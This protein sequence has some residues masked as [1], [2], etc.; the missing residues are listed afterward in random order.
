MQLQVCS[1]RDQ[2]FLS[3]MVFSMHGEGPRSAST[4]M[5]IVTPTYENL[6][7]RM[8]LVSERFS[9]LEEK[10]QNLPYFEIVERTADFML[11]QHQLRVAIA[12]SNEVGEDLEDKHDARFDPIALL[13]AYPDSLDSIVMFVEAEMK[14]SEKDLLER[15]G[16][17]LYA[18]NTL[19]FAAAL[20]LARSESISSELMEFLVNHLLQPNP[21]VTSKG[22]GRPKGINDDLLFKSNAIKFAVAHGLTP[23]RNDET[24]KKISACDAVVQ[25][26]RKLYQDK[27]DKKFISGHTYAALKKVWQKDL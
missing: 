18:Y 6:L 23:T 9:T 2:E 24:K 17:S 21:P 10:P 14:A 15:K 7:D 22:R 25:A 1:N 12:F 8:K 27:G 13:E 5:F 20:H 3:S 26:G 19:V 16:K 11:S 4:W